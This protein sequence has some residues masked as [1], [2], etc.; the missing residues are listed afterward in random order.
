MV[1]DKHA[2]PPGRADDADID[3]LRETRRDGQQIGAGLHA[4]T[5]ERTGYRNGYR[6]R[7]WDTRAGTIGLIEV[8]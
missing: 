5:P 1:D 6:P 3:F 2:D 7:R 8:A 4:H